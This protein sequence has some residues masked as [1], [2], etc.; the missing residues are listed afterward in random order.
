MLKFGRSLCTPSGQVSR[1]QLIHPQFWH[2]RIQSTIG[3]AHRNIDDPHTMLL[4]QTAK[5]IT[6]TEVHTVTRE[7]SLALAMSI[8]SFSS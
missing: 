6:D 7:D 8:Q 1:E 3:F 2:Q 5:F 4:Q